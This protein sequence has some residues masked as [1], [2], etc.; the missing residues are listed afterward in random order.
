M[1]GT[2]IF[3]LVLGGAALLA[4]GV[5]LGGRASADHGIGERPAK[6]QVS[7]H[8][9]TPPDRAA[10]AAHPPALPQP[11]VAPG[12]ADDLRDNDPL[13]RRNAIAELAATGA[14]DPRVLAEASRDSDLNVAV[15]ATEGLG[16][17]YRDGQV[18]ASELVARL[19]DGAPLKV[20]VAAINALGV[21]ASVDSA[22]ALIDLLAHGSEIDRRSAAIVLVHQDPAVAVPA[23]IA[24]LRDSDENVRMNARESLRTFARG[25]DLGSEADAWSRWWQTRSR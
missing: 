23:L 24:A 18:P 15:A 16:T 17:L 21:V 20:R 3:G 7:Q 22:D 1:R 10:R 25:R 12:L 4:T 6:A 5:W 11:A 8:D 19:R 2:A 13:V 14:A 9:R